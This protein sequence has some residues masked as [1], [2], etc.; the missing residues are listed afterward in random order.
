[1]NR[2]PVISLLIVCFW[3]NFSQ[4]QTVKK[5][6][7]SATTWQLL[8]YDANR[9][10]KGITHAATRPLHWKGKDFEKLGRI[11]LG[12]VML[13]AIDQPSSDFLRRQEKDVPM[14]IREFGFYFGQPQNYLMASAGLYGVGLLTKNEKIR[15]TS[16]LILSSAAT[17]GYIQIF[18]RT[19][20]GR[21]RPLGEDGAFT[22]KPFKGGDKYYSF[23]SGHMVL[24]MTMAHSVAKQ[25]DNIWV[26][27]GIY[28]VGSI[29]GF[30]RLL[31][32]KHWLSDV[33]VGTALAIVVVD[34]V[35]KFLFGSNSYD[36]P[37]KDKKVTWNFRVGG[38]Q[39][40]VVGTF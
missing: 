28:S 21:A 33:A 24:G 3:I 30:S 39:I 2:L 8:K 22:F 7:D 9:T 13:S 27:I 23:P 15:R 32:G 29:P 19:A 4:A 40:G 18:A 1:M 5:P 26:K 31:S 16:V 35:D 10:I 14:V 34:S 20:F 12:S 37:K 11:V 6:S 38:S 17:A 25:F 36:V